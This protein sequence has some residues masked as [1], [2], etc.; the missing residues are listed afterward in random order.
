VDD[1]LAARGA[2]IGTHAELL[3]VL[4]GLGIAMDERL[5]VP[6]GDRVCVDRAGRVLYRRH[7]GHTMSAWA[8]VYRPL[9]ARLPASRY[10]FGRSF[11]RLEQAKEKVFAHFAD[12]ASAEGDLLVGADGLRSAVRAQLFPG[13]EPAYAGYVAWRA[14]VPDSTLPARLDEWLGGQYWFVLPPGEMMLCYPVPAKDRARDGRDWN[15]VWYRPVTRERLADFCTDATGRRHSLAAMPP[16]LIRQDVIAALKQDARELLA[17]PLAELVERSQPF[18]QAIFDVE[19]PRLTVGRVVLLGDAA[20]VA[21]PHVGMG[22][23]KAALDALCLAR[24]LEKFP[25]DL[26]CTLRR[27]DELRGEF[28][29]R[30]VARARRLG[31]YIEARSRPDAAWTSAQLDQSPARVLHETAASLSDIAELAALEI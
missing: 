17:G 20:F 23:T 2:G 14:M 8:N 11:C 10:R 4:A 18:F 12:G 19:S 28:G 31:A 27:Y 7:W 22:V 13:V 3:A 21:R 5:G 30:C 16:P 15:I 6:V 25:D 29:R 9:K 1:D 24:S 26:S